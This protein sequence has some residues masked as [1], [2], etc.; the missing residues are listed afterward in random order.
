MTNSEFSKKHQQ[1]FFA[2]TID[3]GIQ[4]S[5]SNAQ[6]RK[7]YHITKTEQTKEEFP[8]SIESFAIDPEQY[9]ALMERL[10]SLYD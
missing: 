8:L 7:N 10:K 3:G 4:A 9:Y 6:G 5:F 2:K 1:H